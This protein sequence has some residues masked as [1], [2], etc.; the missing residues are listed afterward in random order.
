MKKLFTV[1]STM[2][3]SVLLLAQTPQSFSYQTVIRDNSWQI[4]A[5]QNIGIKISIIEDAPNGTVIYEESHNT[6]TSTVGLVNLAIGEGTV[7][8]GTFNTID[9]GNHS[10]FIEVAVDVN[11]GTNYL[12][13]G[14]T[15]LR[16]VP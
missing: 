2:I 16:S 9:W 3:F 13:M 15:R 8:S 12:V 5:N 4:L 14:T 1:L 6:S 7:I 11:G 10:Y